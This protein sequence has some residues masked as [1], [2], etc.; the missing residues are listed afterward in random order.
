M[1]YSAMTLPSHHDGE[2]ARMLPVILNALNC[3]R[4]RL[5]PMLQPL[6]KCQKVLFVH[7]FRDHDIIDMGLA[8]A[9]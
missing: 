7:P 9:D 1:S 2:K 4:P 6:C 8:S 5:L 3:F